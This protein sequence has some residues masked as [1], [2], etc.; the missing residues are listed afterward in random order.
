P[1]YTVANHF[2]CAV[3]R[4]G[5]HRLTDRASLRQHPRNPLA[6]RRMHDDIH[7][8]DVLRYVRRRDTPGHH[9]ALTDPQ[10]ISAPPDVVPQWTVAD[11]QEVDV[12]DLARD[13]CRHLEKLIM[14]LQWKQSRDLSNHQRV[15]RYAGAAFRFVHGETLVYRQEQVQIDS[16]EDGRVLSRM[17]DPIRYCGRGDTRTDA[18]DPSRERGAQPFRDDEQPVLPRGLELVKRQPVLRMD[19]HGDTSSA[20]SEAPDDSRLRR[21]RMHHVVA[22]A[23]QEP[24][25]IHERLHVGQWADL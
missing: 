18:N 24:V 16:A 20:G 12:R 10:A 9:E 22:A 1:R 19:D 5:H 4:E 23:P 15:D 7:R 25:H 6:Q 21:M 11:E 17:T 2:G 14:P 3:Q 13:A 8:L